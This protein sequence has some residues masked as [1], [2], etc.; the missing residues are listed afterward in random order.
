[1]IQKNVI[2]CF[3]LKMPNTKTRTFIFWMSYQI[4]DSK[5]CLTLKLL[6]E[7]K[8]SKKNMCKI[9]TNSISWSFS[10]I[11]RLQT[12]K[13]QNIV[14]IVKKFRDFR[15]YSPRVFHVTFE[16]AIRS[17]IITRKKIQ[18]SKHLC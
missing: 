17:P 9:E 11:A 8:V 2:L 3:P 1:M 14:N 10:S 6:Q 15:F 16:N 5:N 4:C 7:C 12:N 18:L 13:K